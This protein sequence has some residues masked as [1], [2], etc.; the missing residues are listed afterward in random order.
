MLNSIKIIEYKF[1]WADFVLFLEMTLSRNVQF[2]LTF[3]VLGL[4]GAGLFDY[5]R[6]HDENECSMTFMFQNPDLIGVP[7]GK[8]VEAKYPS[9]KL[10][11]YCEGYECQQHQRL[12]FNQPGNIPILFITGKKRSILSE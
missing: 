9:Y 6:N 7:L 4:F 1:K 11:L 8:S 2:V 10:F 12:N 5:L 3:A